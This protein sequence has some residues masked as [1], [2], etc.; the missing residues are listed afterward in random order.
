MYSFINSLIWINQKVIYVEDLLL[1]KPIEETP[2]AIELFRIIE[3]KLKDCVELYTNEAQ[4]ISDRHKSLQLVKNV[5]NLDALQ[6]SSKRLL[7]L[8]DD[9]NIN[10]CCFNS[11][12]DLRNIVEIF[13][14][15]EGHKHE[16]KFYIKLF[17]A[18][19]QIWSP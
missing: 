2:K 9:M 16:N 15:Q 4:A 13:F 1:F 14:S 8:C 10:H 12:Y 5:H 11:I 17:L 19:W 3:L 6:D 7:I 18:T